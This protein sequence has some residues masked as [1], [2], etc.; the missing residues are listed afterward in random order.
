MFRPMID[1]H[2]H[3]LPGIDDGPSSFDESVALV[4]AAAADGTTRIVATPHV[5]WHY[6]NDAAT[7]AGL[8]S[9]LNE[10]LV[11]QGI[12]VQVEAGA[13]IAMTR[14]PEI[15]QD[16]LSRLALAGGRWLLIEPPF[17]AA[18]PTFESTVLGLMDDGHAVLVAHPERCQALRRDASVITRLVRAGALMSITA[19]S[20]TGRFG[21]PV[22]QFAT[23]LIE[24]RLVHNVASDAHDASGRPPA[25]ASEIE[26]AGLGELREWLTELV[27]AAILAGE[28]QMPARPHRLTAP[29][30]RRR[31]LLARLRYR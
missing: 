4:R 7:I 16:E 23:R 13:E 10:L 21:A 18:A 24:E 26:R 15:D 8:V 25:L 14:L 29:P 19:G 22:R 20:L 5:S 27:P 3:A 31:G 11:E 17:A 28:Q 1:L 12:S 2:F 9:R 6:P 30:H